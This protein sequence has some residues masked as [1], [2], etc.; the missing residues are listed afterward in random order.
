MRRGGDLF[1]L[2][3]QSQRACRVV[4]PARSGSRGALIGRDLLR[5]VLTRRTRSRADVEPNG[6][7]PRPALRSL[8]AGLAL[9]LVA[10]VAAAQ[11]R[12][13]EEA[14]EF[15]RGDLGGATAEIMEAADLEAR[16]VVPSFVTVGRHVVPRF[17][18]RTFDLWEVGLFASETMEYG[19]NVRGDSTNPRSDV[20]SRTTGGVRL[21]RD[22]SELS[23]SASASLTGVAFRRSPKLNSLDRQ[24]SVSVWYGSGPTRFSIAARYLRLSEIGARTADTDGRQGVLLSARERRR[25]SSIGFDVGAEYTWTK[26]RLAAAFR[27]TRDAYSG[28]TNLDSRLD[29]WS[30]RVGYEIDAKLSTSLEASVLRR[31]REAGAAD[32]RGDRVAAGIVWKSSPSLTVDLEVGN[33]REDPTGATRGT[34]SSAGRLIVSWV[35]SPLTLV[36]ADLYRDLYAAAGDGLQKI[37][38]LDLATVWDPIGPWS[39]QL[40][41]HTQR[42]TGSSTWTLSHGARFGY[43]TSD[44]SEVAL[45]VQLIR[46]SGSGGTE[47]KRVSVEFTVGF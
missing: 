37:T 23:V 38:S 9:F 45:L 11:D 46:E 22:A 26:T 42:R 41:L 32:T 31:D 3:V 19:D 36:R 33:I 5:R 47:S 2:N 10:S 24:G 43:R 30:L 39:A 28:S 7:R 1:A 18:P 4:R 17:A 15:L 16:A 29:E 14:R 13:A 27:S 6:H 25:R 35:A 21:G 40:D 44:D 20:L 12:G 8:G 34:S